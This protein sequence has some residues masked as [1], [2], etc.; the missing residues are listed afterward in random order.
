M[1]RLRALT[2]RRYGATQV[3]LALIGLA[4]YEALRRALT[5][6]WTLALRHAR[7]VARLEA[8]LHVGWERP[9]QAWFLGAPG[10]VQVLDVFYVVGHFGL[11]ALFLAWLYRRSLPAFRRFRNGLVAST[12]LALAISA[13]FPTAPPRIAE[14]GVV[15][16]LRRLSGIDIGSPG[17]LGF[18]DPVAAIPSLH[19][20]WAFALGAGLVVYGRGWWR[21]AG[22]VYPALMVL[23]ILV[24]G[25]HFVLDAVAGV[26]V[27][28]SGFLVT[29]PRVVPF[30][31]RRGVE[32]SG[33]SPGS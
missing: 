11:T 29:S 32:Q 17:S 30:Q 23:T 31:L 4:A 25:N 8:S 5:P 10:L 2:V 26:V 22:A 20:G 21:L 16:T 7:D 27:T 1:T 28:A 15:D 19:A 14:P 13:G 9:L 6:D 12:V 3:A 18:S 33:S 24:T